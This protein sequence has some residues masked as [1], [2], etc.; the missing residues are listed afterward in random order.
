MIFV[1]FGNRDGVG[2]KPCGWIGVLSKDCVQSVEKGLLCGGAEVFEEVV[3]N[4]VWSRA[5]GSG[6]LN[7]EL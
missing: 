7:G 4:V 1:W 5:G 3:V 2:V 6:A